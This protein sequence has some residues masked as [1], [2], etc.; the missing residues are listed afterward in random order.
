MHF[1][2]SIE[3]AVAECD[4]FVNEHS[5]TQTQRHAKFLLH[6]ELVNPH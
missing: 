2:G 6:T 1:V 5:L 3:N 4:F